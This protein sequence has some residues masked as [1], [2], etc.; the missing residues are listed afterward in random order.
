[1]LFFFVHEHEGVKMK[2]GFVH[3]RFLNEE[4]QKQMGGISLWSDGPQMATV[5][6]HV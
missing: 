3:V 6:T 5:N 4:D 2:Q 1:M